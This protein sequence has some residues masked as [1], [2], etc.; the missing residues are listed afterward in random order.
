VEIRPGSKALIRDLNTSHVLEALRRYGPCSRGEVVRRTRL[1]RAT[2]TDIL[3]G[4]VREGFLHNSGRAGS[5]GGRPA[6]LI[7]LEPRARLSAGFALAG[8][9]LDAVLLDLYGQRVA[10]SHCL[11][12]PGL[13]PLRLAAVIHRELEQLLAASG[14]DRSTLT[15]AGVVLPGQIDPASGMVCESYALGWSQVPLGHLLEEVLGLRVA[16]ANDA[17]GLALAERYHGHQPGIANLTAVLVGTGVGAGI[18]AGGRLIRGATAAVGELGHTPVRPSGARCT[19]G[20]KGCL[21]TVASET[22]VLAEAGLPA[23]WLSGPSPRPL[24][25]AP[26]VQQ[27]IQRAGEALGTSLAFL[28]NLLSPGL[29]VLGGRLP[30]AASSRL[31][32]PLRHALRTHALPLVGDSLQVVIS[33][34]GDQACATGAGIAVLEEFFSPP[35]YE[36]QG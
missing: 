14:A 24:P 12:D 25:D 26:E 1:S 27:A 29:I 32:E 30:E 21:Q 28:A 6:E 13:T 31:L 3:N 2:V 33:H 35:I 8:R 34:L 5:S 10:N 11:C 20:R 19:C 4:L 16:L 15:G 36:P 23:D 17:Q 9:R 18:I 7:R 22:A